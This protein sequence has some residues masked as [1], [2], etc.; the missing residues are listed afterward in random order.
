M[1]GLVY[2][3]PHRKFA[4]TS[5]QCQFDYGEMDER[6]NGASEYA[7]RTSVTNETSSSMEWRRL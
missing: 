1:S 4:E 5:R 7:S 6:S 3:A 2:H